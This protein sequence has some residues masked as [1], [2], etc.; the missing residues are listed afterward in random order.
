MGIV[1]VISIFLFGLIANISLIQAA[2]FKPLKGQT[3]VRVCADAH[4]LPYSN[5]K[6]EGFD[7]KIAALIGEQLGIPVEYTWFPQRIGFTRNT[8]KKV[9]RETGMYLCD[10]AMSM[11]AAPGRLAKTKPY[12]SSIETMVYRTGEGYE[13]NQISDIAKLSQEGNK[14][15]IGLFDRAV[16]TETLLNNGLADQIKYYN[17]MAGDARVYPGR[18]VEDALASGEIDVAFVWGP[19]GSYYASASEVPMTVIP[20]NE[21]GQ[22]FIFS[23]ALGVRHG[24]DHWKDLLNEILE[25]NHDQVMAIMSE[26]SFP[27]L[28]NVEIIEVEPEN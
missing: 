3:A 23:F 2:D 4:N 28:S 17:F 1:R 16:A 20:L 5:D 8:I 13:L 25:A 9:D 7:N 27:D 11:P 6:L 21:L 12:F 14:L 10:L 26:Y 22:R 15:K 19:I 18:I 24:D